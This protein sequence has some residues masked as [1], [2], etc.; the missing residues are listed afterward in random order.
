MA[1]NNSSIIYV[2]D[3][4][5]Q[6]DLE[7][8]VA[9]KFGFQIRSGNLLDEEKE[10]VQGLLVWHQLVDERY[11]FQFP[12]LKA[13]VRYGVGFDNIDL[14]FLNSVGMPFA[15]TPDYGTDEVADTAVTMLLC[16]VRGVT[17]YQRIVMDL[18]D[19]SWQ[20][21]VI[22]SIKRTKSMTIGIIGLGRIGT[23]VAL[24]C[25]ALGFGVSFYDPHLPSGIEKSLS[26]T[27]HRNLEN[28]LAASDVVT[29]HTPLSSST[30]GLIDSNFLSQMKNG[31]VLI[32][33]ARGG[34]LF[35]LN[36]IFE[37]LEV[38]RLSFAGLD[39]IP[40]EPL[41]NDHQQHPKMLSL[42][43]SGK[44]V[45][46]PHTAYYSHESFVEMRESSTMNI[47]RY[48]SGVEPLMNQ[49]RSAAVVKL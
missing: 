4:I 43:Q 37:A 12:N 33:T 39:V 7:L 9:A 21:N 27:R 16:G 25:R 14:D 28:L 13:V 3:Y 45:I 26:L 8:E 10:R 11:L 38:G 36:L 48:L 49:I 5:E 41:S 35:D 44:L 22:H 2:T 24:K 23:S 31:S 42:M 40:E 29:I 46:N 18:S 30:E 32:N 19:G 47:C 1:L 34:I 17:Q 20:E 15:N 6:P